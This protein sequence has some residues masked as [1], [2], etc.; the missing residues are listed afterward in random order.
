MSAPNTASPTHSPGP[1]TPGHRDGDDQRLFE[2]ALRWRVSGWR[3]GAHR[4]REEGRMGEFR[5]LVPFQRSPESRLDLRSSLRDPFGTLYVR[6]VA[7]RTAADVHVLLDSSG[8]MAFGAGWRLQRAGRIAQAAQAIHDRF[9]RAAGAEH[10]DLYESARRHGIDGMFERLAQVPVGGEQ[11]HGLLAAAERLG[12]RR[13]LVVLLSDFEF[14]PATLDELLTALAGHD[15]VPVRLCE[16]MHDDLPRYGLMALRDL[17]SGHR[18]L[19]WLR[20]SLRERWQA[21]GRARRQ[22]LGRQ[23][24]RH[25]CRALDLPGKVDVMALTRHLREA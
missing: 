6:Q 16:A 13:K 10:L 22:Q 1:G 7:Q 9:G 20:P 17:E 5:R 18:R 15:V 11:R 24:S 12:R 14:P 25:G 3:A 4:G 19:L 2:S 21:Q 8:S 23:F